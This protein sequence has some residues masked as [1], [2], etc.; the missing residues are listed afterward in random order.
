MNKL[1]FLLLIIIGWS[2][3]HGSKTEKYQ[4]KRENIVQVRNRIKEIEMEDVLINRNAQLYS[5]RE[6]LI[7]CDYKSYDKQILLFDKKS[8]RYIAG[9]A[10]KGEGPDEVTNIGYVGIDEANRKFYV[11]DHGRHKIF[12]Y[13]VDSVVANPLYKREVKMNMKER[14]F[15]HKYQYV[16]DTLCMGII[17]E[18]TGNYGFNQSVSAW[19]M[20][21]GEIKP[22]SYVHPEIEKKRVSFAVSLEKGIYVECYN[23]H[24]LMTICGLDGNLKCN[25]YGSK[26]N[27]RKTNSVCYYGDV[28]FCD[29]RIVVS[30]SAGKDNFAKV[31]LYPTEFLVFDTNGDYLQTLE[32]GYNI[33]NFC[34]DKD[35]NRIIMSLDDE[36]QFAYL[37]LDGLML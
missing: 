5:I 27:S 9:T 1:L 31:E 23:H 30:N 34:Y 29:D 20:L 12:G 37:D 19:N 6:Y 18:P 22:M 24:D 16:S 26:W 2:C 36:I 35:N 13:N 10:Y 21:T 25:I 28:V 14:R 7:I 15:P 32:T 11:T 17:I 8:F 4:N 3:T 33:S